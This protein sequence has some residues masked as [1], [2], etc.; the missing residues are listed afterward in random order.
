MLHLLNMT[1]Y[2]EITNM[3]HCYLLVNSTLLSCGK[4]KMYH[5][6]LFSINWLF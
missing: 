3:T 4:N 5:I 2:V 6:Y 1:V